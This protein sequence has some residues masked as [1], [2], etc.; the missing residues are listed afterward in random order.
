MFTDYERW[1]SI[2]DSWWIKYCPRKH[3][4]RPLSSLNRKL[5][6]LVSAIW[7]FFF[8]SSS[9]HAVLIVISSIIEGIERRSSMGR[10]HYVHVLWVILFCTCIMGDIIM[11]SLSSTEPSVII[12]MSLLFSCM[13]ESS[14]IVNL[15]SF[16][17]VKFCP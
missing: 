11:C 15:L 7:Y 8:F 17:W 16:S 3:W 6:L 12:S 10:Y 5:F 4:K 1:L 9:P 13:V 2:T 14:I